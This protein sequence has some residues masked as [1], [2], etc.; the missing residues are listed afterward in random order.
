MPKLT[1]ESINFTVPP[2]RS[3]APKPIFLIFRNRLKPIIVTTA[4]NV[5]A[6]SVMTGKAYVCVSSEV[7][8]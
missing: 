1:R 2:T 6:D 7:A 4:V 8:N 3:D 5:K